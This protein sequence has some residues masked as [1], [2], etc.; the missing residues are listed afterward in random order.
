MNQDTITVFQVRNYCGLG[1]SGEYHS[2]YRSNVK[3]EPPRLPD[4]LD[5]EWRGTQE[6]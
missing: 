5:V 1:W 4:G 3:T 2:V 6:P